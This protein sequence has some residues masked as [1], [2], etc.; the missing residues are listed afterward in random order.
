MQKEMASNVTTYVIFIGFATVAAAPF[1]FGLS[2]T[3]LTVIQQIVGGVGSSLSSDSA[4]GGGML[5]FQID[6]ESVDLGNFK[7]YSLAMLTVTSTFS[8]AIIST[9]QKGTVK[10]GAKYIP[11]FILVTFLLYLIAVKLLG[12]LFGGLL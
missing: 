2:T 10:A 6:S 7:L 11:V 12:I 9:I 5:S 8:A 4:A 1:L 3:L